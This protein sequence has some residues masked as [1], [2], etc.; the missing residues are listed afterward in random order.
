MSQ[1]ART[2][3]CKMHLKIMKVMNSTFGLYNLSASAFFN[4]SRKVIKL[5]LEILQYRQPGIMFYRFEFSFDS[6]Q[7]YP[8]VW[9]DPFFFQFYLQLPKQHLYTITNKVEDI[10]SPEKMKSHQS[11]NKSGFVSAIIGG[12]LQLFSIPMIT[13]KIN[14]QP[15][16]SAQ[17][18]R[19]PPAVLFRY[20]TKII[21]PS[22][23]T[24]RY[25]TSTAR[26]L[27]LF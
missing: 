8:C 1:W 6:N 26:R 18:P 17:N 23:I 19:I 11:K 16:G 10:S 27:Y 12:G 4:A 21:D 9:Q 2:L 20:K 24:L 22:I 14:T 25:S 13:G 3:N 7:V 15:C 5:L